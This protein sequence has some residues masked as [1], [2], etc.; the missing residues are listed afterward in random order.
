MFCRTKN[1]KYKYSA[2][3]GYGEQVSDTTGD[4][5][6]TMAGKQIFPEK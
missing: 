4:A 5:I 2:A 6:C 1:R 3:Q